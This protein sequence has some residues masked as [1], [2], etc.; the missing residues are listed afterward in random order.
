M[1]AGHFKHLPSQSNWLVLNS[2]GH[3]RM[4][5]VNW[6]DDVVNVVT[7]IFVLDLDKQLFMT[8]TIMVSTHYVVT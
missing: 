2:T 6:Q 3:T 4:D 8:L 1:Y 7:Q 5:T